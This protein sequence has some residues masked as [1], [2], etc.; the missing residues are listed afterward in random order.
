MQASPAAAA[1]TSASGESTADAATIAAAPGSSAAAA[2][3]SFMG[4]TPKTGKVCFVCR[5]AVCASLQN[6]V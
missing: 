4:A 1:G 6:R 2:A 3:A 5:Q